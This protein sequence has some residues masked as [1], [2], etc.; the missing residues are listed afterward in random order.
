MI[1]FVYNSS[2]RGEDKKMYL[3]N[4]IYAE[5]VSNKAGNVKEMF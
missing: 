5:F 1:L 4:E 3:E 2:K